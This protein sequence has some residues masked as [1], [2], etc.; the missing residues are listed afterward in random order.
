MASFAGWLNSAV[1]VIC[2]N[3]KKADIYTA[4]PYVY[5]FLFTFFKTMFRKAVAQ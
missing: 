2:K 1:Q 5:A 3:N 4:S